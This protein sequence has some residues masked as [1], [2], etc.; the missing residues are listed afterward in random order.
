MIYP[1]Q[2]KSTLWANIDEMAVNPRRFA[3]NSKLIS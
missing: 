1:E 2:V 3:T